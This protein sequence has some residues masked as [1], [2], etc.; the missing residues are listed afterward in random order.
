MSTFRR[1]DVCSEEMEP[2]CWRGLTATVRGAE[3]L[4]RIGSV[5]VDAITGPDICRAC[6]TAALRKAE[7]S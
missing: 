5:T 1:C 4:V 3:I 7:P 2:Q 6:L